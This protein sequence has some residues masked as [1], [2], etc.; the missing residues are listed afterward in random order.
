MTEIV[1]PRILITGIGSFVGSHIAYAA[2]KLG[3]RVRGK[4]PI[5]I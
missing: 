4:N 1:A 5:F 2:L 3:Y